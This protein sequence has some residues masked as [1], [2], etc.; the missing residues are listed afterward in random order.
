M[1][2]VGLIISEF[3]GQIGG[4]V[5]NH[6]GD[7]A[8]EGEGEGDDDQDA[9]GAPEPQAFEAMNQGGKEKREQEG[10][11]QGN[12]DGPREIESRDHSADG[13]EGEKRPD[14]LLAVDS[15]M[16]AIVSEVTDWGSGEIIRTALGADNP[17]RPRKMARMADRVSHEIG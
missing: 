12:Q 16:G 14:L 5:G 2:D 8:E 11:G 7:A 9:G 3:D 4:L 10:D 1:L 15:P 6:P 13:R 17:Y